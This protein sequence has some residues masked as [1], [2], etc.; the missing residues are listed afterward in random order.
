MHCTKNWSNFLILEADEVFQC[1]RLGEK[2]KQPLLTIIL[3]FLIGRNVG[4][5]GTICRYM[6]RTYICLIDK[7]LITLLR[8]KDSFLVI[9]YIII[10]SKNSSEFY[11]PRDVITAFIKAWHFSLFSERWMQSV[12]SCTFSVKFRYYYH[13][14]RFD[15]LLHTCSGFPTKNLYAF[16]FSPILSTYPAHFIL[17]KHPNSIWHEVNKNSGK[18]SFSILPAY[19]LLFKIFLC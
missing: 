19:L 10:T 1:Q 4:E 3:W 9:Q 15:L 14:T 11:W 13:P 6:R 17:L 16:V 2:A 7:F 18:I 8:G 12:L 5:K